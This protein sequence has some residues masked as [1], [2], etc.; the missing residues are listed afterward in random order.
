MDGEENLPAVIAA[1]IERPVEYRGERVIT[2]RM[3]DEF[4]ERPEGTAGRNFRQHRG[5]HLLEGT[6]YFEVDQADEIRRLGLEPRPQGGTD[7][8]LILLTQAGYLMLVKTFTDDLAWKIQDML[9]RHYFRSETIT[10]AEML[11]GFERVPP[12]LEKLVDGQVEMRADQLAMRMDINDIKPRIE[13]VEDVVAKW[14]KRNALSA[15]TVR[16]HCD[17]IRACYQGCCPCC[18]KTRIVDEYG[19]KLPTCHEEH[20]YSASENQIERTWLTCAECNQRLRDPAVRR[21]RRREFEA[22]QTR[23]EQ[24]EHAKDSRGLFDSADATA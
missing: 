8:R 5:R 13:R 11:R 9:V 10:T 2:L 3:M 15:A 23:R 12:L 18:G 7:A 4:H 14:E 20:A 19:A 16:R 17:A 24:Y 6:H 1:A 22:Y 21:A